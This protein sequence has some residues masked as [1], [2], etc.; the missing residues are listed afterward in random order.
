MGAVETGRAA[1]VKGRAAAAA[2]KVK[3]TQLAIRA[4]EIAKEKSF[5][6]TAASAAGGAVTLGTTGGVA[7]LATGTVVGAAVGVVPALFTFGLSI[8]VFAA[9][10]GTCGLVTGAAAGGTVGAVG[11][12]AAG[13]GAFQNREQITK[14]VSH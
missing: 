2:T 1:G 13:Y 9:I 14:A 10:G 8:P 5:Q 4:R 7:G 6:V 11:G 12:G 3:A